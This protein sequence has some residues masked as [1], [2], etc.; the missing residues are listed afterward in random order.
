M[1]NFPDCAIAN[2]SDFPQPCS[3]RVQVTELPV[4]REFEASFVTINIM[5]MRNLIWIVLG[6]FAVGVLSA[7][8]FKSAVISKT[9]NE[10]KVSESSKEARSASSGQIIG[11]SSTVLTGRESRAELSFTDKTIT[12]IGA[13]SVFSFKSGTRDMAINQGSFLLQVPKNAGGATIRTATV[14]AAITGTTTMMEYSPGKWI[15][16]ICLEG[17]AEL[18]NKF[19]DKVRIGYGMMIVMNPN[20]K[21]FPKPV[22]V[23]LEKLVKTS[24]LMDLK[25]F[26][27]LNSVAVSLIDQSSENQLERRREG[28]LIPGRL[29]V[30]GSGFRDDGLGGGSDTTGA[31]TEGSSPRSLLDSGHKG[32]SGGANDPRCF[33]IQGNLIPGC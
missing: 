5:K 4:V 17:E 10:V 23:N 32:S 9:V 22:F 28:I 13:N 18:S 20:A 15:K 2:H 31:S 12:R 19:D 30:R 27:N 3:F 14:T 33:D 11:K 8:P 1:G 26:G 7:A 29:M 6:S 16:F 24:K 25:I 21:K